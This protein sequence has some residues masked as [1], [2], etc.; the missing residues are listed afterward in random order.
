MVQHFG[1]WAC[2]YCQ[3]SPPKT[4]QKVDSWVRNRQLLHYNGIQFGRSEEG[5]QPLTRR[6]ACKIGRKWGEWLKSKRQIKIEAERVGFEPTI[7][8][9]IRA[10][11]ARALGHYATSPKWTKCIKKLRKSK[12]NILTDFPFAYKLTFH[13]ISHMSRKRSKSSHSFFSFEFENI[14]A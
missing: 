2:H 14:I 7:P 10:F 6:I 9:G 8:F 5:V 3:K 13:I 12:M 1:R 4:V 11:Q